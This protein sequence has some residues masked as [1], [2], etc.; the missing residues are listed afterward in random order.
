MSAEWVVDEGGY[1]PVRSTIGS[2][3]YDL[4][5]PTDMRL[6]TGVWV[7]VDF[8]VRLVGEPGPWFVLLL[9]RSG[10]G[11]RHGLELANTAGVIDSSYRD[12]IKARL[13]VRRMDTGRPEGGARDTIGSPVLDV[14]AGDRILQAVV[15]PFAA[16]RNDLAPTEERRGGL[17]STGV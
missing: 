10:L 7:D 12:T 8:K 2:A 6:R 11:F 13:T 1:M 14:R 17:G 9:P 16:M 4:A 5:S 3:G 15:V